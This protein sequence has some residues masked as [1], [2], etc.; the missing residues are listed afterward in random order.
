LLS[1]K[2]Y[3]LGIYIST[4]NSIPVLRAIEE[5]NLLGEVQIIATDLFPELVP[6]IE[7]GRILATLYQRP[8][9][10]GKT[11]LEILVRYLLDGVTPE[12]HTR[13]APHIILRSNLALFASY[14]TEG[15]DT[16]SLSEK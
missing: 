5:K 7:S 12:L 9:T 15:A 3:P 8:F 14:I 1:R 10:Q 16:P 2:P 13:L 4:A 11:A 6:Y